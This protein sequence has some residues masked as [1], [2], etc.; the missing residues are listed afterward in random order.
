M[1]TAKNSIWEITEVLE[2]LVATTWSTF[3]GTRLV[4]V[5]ALHP[6]DAVV[7]ASIAVS[8]PA[9]A[10]VLF[11]MDTALSRSCTSSVLHVLPGEIVDEEIHDVVGELVNII[12]GNLK[13]MVGEHDEV[14]TLSLPVV[15]NA[16]QHAPG[17]RLVAEASFLTTGG[18]LGCHILEHT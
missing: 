15:S 1:R 10:T 6:G 4:R 9:S 12:G 8:G 14:W 2:D 3:I 16:M 17:S 7:C 18:T 11:F 5:D 13:G